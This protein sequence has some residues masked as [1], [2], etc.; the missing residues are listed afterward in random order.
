MATD[1]PMQLGMVGLGRMGA[2]LVRRLMRDGHRCVVYD[3]TVDAVKE[4]EAEGATGA[5]SL[6]DFAVR[7]EKPRTAWL[8]LPAAVVDST[9]GRLVPLLEPGDAVIDG[10]NSNY[11]DDITRAK[12]LQPRGIHYVD[13]G[14]SGGVWGLERGYSLMIGGETE[15]AA[16]LDPIFKTIAPGAGTAEPT[17]SRTRRG[18]A[19]PSP[20][21]M[22]A[23][24]PRW[25]GHAALTLTLT[26]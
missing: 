1:T 4:L 23:S 15:V 11:R 16:R 14:T 8:M 9:L 2:N 22:R 19:S 24:P 6:E 12:Q 7:L 3:V 21:R 20:M 18:V 17:P 5:T 26:E 13:C 25:S 10:G